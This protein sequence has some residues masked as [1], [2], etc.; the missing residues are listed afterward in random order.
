VSPL[1]HVAVTSAAPR[2][3]RLDAGRAQRDVVPLAAHAELSVPV[4]RP[5]PLA[6]LRAQDATRV[7]ELVPIRYGRMAPTPFTFLRGA[8]AVMS[9]DLADAPRTGIVVQLCGDAHL[10]NFGAFAAPDRRL[11]ADVN[12]FDETLPGPFEW[13]VKRLAASLFVASR[14]N[15][16]DD[17]RT[18]VAV[19]AM[20]ETYRTALVLAAA[21]DP[22]DVWYSRVELDDLVALARGAERKG[23]D[24]VVQEAT[25]KA[26]RKDRHRAA[27]KLTEVVD[28]RRRIADAP[29]LI[30]RA[31]PE[32]LE[33]ELDRIKEFLQ[34]CRAGLTRDRQT[35]LD[36]YSVVDLAHKVVG[37]GSAGTRCWIL[38]LETGDGE[39]LFLQFKE[40]T[41]SVLEPYLGASEFEYAGQRVVE[42]QQL[43][44]AASDL[45]LGWARY[46]RAD[47][48]HVD[49]YFRQLWDGK[50]SAPIGEMG[51]KRLRRYGRFC[52]LVLA[53]AHARSGD[54]AVISGYLGDD[55]AFDRAMVAF[56]QAYADRTHEDHARLVAAVED[57][58]IEVARGL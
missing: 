26:K 9:R 24:G 16:V 2:A 25:E 15:G 44:Q 52:G 43:V 48:T 22:L 21:S 4:D 45:F 33:A 57:G 8:A 32:Q 38:L 49:Y 56:A 3:D 39:P 17:E 14:D 34:Q 5:D 51:P 19:S 18:R 13:D 28:G 7:A 53:R 31:A 42:G 35:I 12:D 36:R 54:A 55:D 47:G 1:E 58:E 30:I 50:Y 10:A 29:P 27:R 11:V 37:V 46:P 41:A 23:L 40:A 20:V 6:I